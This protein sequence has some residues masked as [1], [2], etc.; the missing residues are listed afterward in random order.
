MKESSFV[1]DLLCIH[2]IHKKRQG[3]LDVKYVC[4]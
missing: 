1:P 2:N 3:T 4:T